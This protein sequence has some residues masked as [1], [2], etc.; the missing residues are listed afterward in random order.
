MSIPVIIVEDERLVAQD[1]AQILRDEGYTI[2]AIAVDAQT[3]IQKILEYSPKLVL[4]DIRIKGDIDGIKLAQFIQ[5]FC[6]IPVVY[7]TAFSDAETLKRAQSTNPMGYV[8]KP[9]R[10][11]QLLSTL[12]IALTTHRA[13][14]DEQK[15]TTLKEK[16]LSVVSHELRT[17]LN[18]ILGFSDC[19]KEEVFGS[20]NPKQL[21]A[22]QVINSSGDHLLNLVNNMIDLSMLEAGEFKLTIEPMSLASLCQ[23]CLGC[24]A[25]IAAPKRI[26]IESKIQEGIPSMILDERR[27]F[28]ALMH[29]LNNAVKFTPENG[30]IILELTCENQREYQRESNFTTPVRISVTDS[31]IGIAKEDLHRIFQPFKQVDTGYS[32]KYDGM[33]L[34]LTFVKKIIELHGGSIEA[35][36]ELGVGSRFTIIL[37]CNDLSSNQTSELS[38]TAH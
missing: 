18:A 37:P 6:D 10:Q 15:E 26:K 19:L 20:I 35:T 13:Q 17:P 21:E 11:E 31:G 25:K 27:I 16:L 9:F 1:I 29:L 2:C 24:V 30:H 32:R 23:T 38:F 12:A 7:L 8:V 14:N 34:G 5:S 33:G 36:S 28:Q 22:I 3:A 4:L